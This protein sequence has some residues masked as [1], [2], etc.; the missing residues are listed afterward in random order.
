MLVMLSAGPN[1]ETF[2]HAVQWLNFGFG[3]LLL[4]IYLYQ[5]YYM[6]YALFRQPKRYPET[7]Q[8]KR[9][10][11]LIAARNE[12][13]VLPNLLESIR[14]QTYPKRN[15]DVWV[16]ADNCTDRTAD[17][18]RARGARV[19]ERF[20]QREVGKGYAL[21]ALLCHIRDRYGSFSARYDGYIVIDADNVLTP[22][23]VSEMDK[24]FTHSGC[25]AVTSYRNSKNF[26]DNWISSGYALWFLRESKYLN[27]PRHQLGHSCAISGTGFLFSSAI[28]EEEQGWH[29]HLLTEDIEFTNARVLKGEKIAYANEAMLFDEQP[30]TFEQSWKQRKRW[31][32]GMFQVFRKYGKGM[33][34]EMF[35]GR[36]VCYDM[37]MTSL[38]AFVVSCITLLCNVL[39]GIV[40][41]LWFKTT[42]VIYPLLIAS[43]FFFLFVYVLVYFWGVV[44]V[45][46]ERKNIY[47]S[48]KKLFLYTLTFPI[49]LATFL[50][51][52][53]SAFFTKQVKWEPIHHTVVRNE[54]EIYLSAQQ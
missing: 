36:F 39:L 40:A 51:C 12:E 18:A 23:Y 13:R 14:R 10:A 38:P 35:R 24:V 31:A 47:C 16:V 22:T 37:A 44:T 53:L 7:D 42:G 6:F 45:W 46:T 5:F 4:L 29:Y 15:L 27:N 3:A 33:F 1:L 34:R 20:N 28:A 26:S 50:P 49:F 32:K 52:T 9:Y 43:L 30:V 41:G 17:V 21:N 54:R 8:S 19:L 11:I 48:K 2:L 25:R